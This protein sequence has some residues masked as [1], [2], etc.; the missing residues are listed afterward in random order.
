MKVP[1]SHKIPNMEMIALLYKAFVPALNNKLLTPRMETVPVRLVCLL[2]AYPAVEVA[3]G[4]I[5]PSW[6]Y[7]WL[8]GLSYSD[9]TPTGLCKFLWGPSL[10]E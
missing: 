8:C 7:S 1:D 3:L 9:P 5:L 2:G 4:H 6:G 10:P